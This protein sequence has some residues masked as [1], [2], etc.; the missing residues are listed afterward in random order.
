MCGDATFSLCVAVWRAGSVAA[1]WEYRMNP[2]VDREKVRAF[3][4]RH[5]CTHPTLYHT[6]PLPLAGCSFAGSLPRKCELS[7]RDVCVGD[8]SPRRVPAR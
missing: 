3:A 7:E 4:M 5:T 6:L 8:A 2:L 1:H